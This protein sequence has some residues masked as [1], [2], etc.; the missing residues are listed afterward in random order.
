MSA[1]D[2]FADSVSIIAEK[3]DDNK[4]LGVVKNTFTVLMPFIIVGSFATLGNS[5]FTSETTGLAQ[6]SALSFL[7]VMEPAFTAI[8]FAT[9]NTM[10]LAVIVI[11]GWILGERNN[12]NGI[13]CAVVSLSAYVSVVP[14]GLETVVDGVAGMA[15]G[16]PV[17]TLNAG[18]LFIGMILTMVTVEFFCKLNKIERLQIKMPPSVPSAISKSF[19]VLVPIFITLFVIAIAGRLFELASGLYINEALYRFLQ[20]PLEG[21]LQHPAGIIGLVI[22]SQVFWLV[23]IHGGLVISPIRNPILIAALAANIA[24]YE[25]GQTPDQVITMGSWVTF[26]VV[27]G[28]GLILSLN[29]GLLMFSKKDDLRAVAKIGLVPSLFGISEPV[30]FGLPL[31]LN[32]IF[33]IPF[34]LGSGLPA[35]M[36]LAANQFGLIGSNIVDVPFGLPIIVG[37]FLGWGINGVI[38]QLLIIVVGVFIYLPFI[39]LSNR[40]SELAE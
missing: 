13:M 35:A 19:S 7:A 31:V 38:L 34:V 8:N 16:L 20:A 23:G 5:L 21:I 14:Q 3:V 36:L 28:A 26:L 24:A 11:L 29:I 40:Q 25:A 22:I 9:M 2:K 33:A 18:G 37:A 30:V 27:G 15:T 1:F 32:P 4:Y 39:F 17:E 12:E 6:F 10:T